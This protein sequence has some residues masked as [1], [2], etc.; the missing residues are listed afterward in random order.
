[1]V[2]SSGSLELFADFV[3]IFQI[4]APFFKKVH[5]EVLHESFF[6]EGPHVAVWEFI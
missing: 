5:A 2:E 6:V 4:L 3:V 1:M